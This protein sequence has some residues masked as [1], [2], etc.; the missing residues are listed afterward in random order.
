MECAPTPTDITTKIAMMLA[1]NGDM[2]P[3]LDAAAGMSG[4]FVRDRLPWL[5]R[6]ITPG[7][8]SD[9]IVCAF[10]EAYAEQ[11][12]DAAAKSF[13][14]LEDSVKLELQRELYCAAIKAMVDPLEAD[15]IREVGDA[16]ADNT[17]KGGHV[18]LKHLDADL[19]AA[20]EALD[21]V[22]R[23]VL[24]KDVEEIVAAMI[25]NMPIVAPAP[26]RK[27]Q[28]ADHASTQDPKKRK[29]EN[30]EQTECARGVRIKADVTAMLDKTCKSKSNTVGK[31][32]LLAVCNPERCGNRAYWSGRHTK[33]WIRQK[34]IDKL[35]EA[36]LAAEDPSSVCDEWKARIMRLEAFEQL[37]SQIVKAIC[38]AYGVIEETRRF[39]NPDFP[40]HLSRMVGLLERNAVAPVGAAQV[41]DMRAKAAEALWPYQVPN[42]IADAIH[43]IA[44]NISPAGSKPGEGVDLA[45][46]DELER[47]VDAH[48][49]NARAACNTKQPSTT[50]QRMHAIA[51][52]FR[53]PKNTFKLD[54]IYRMLW[55]VEDF[56]RLNN[57][58]RN[59][60][61]KRALDEFEK[62]PKAKCLASG[63]VTS[64]NSGSEGRLCDIEAEIGAAVELSLELVD[65]KP[66]W[67]ARLSKPMPGVVL[68]EPLPVETV[69]K[70]T[71]IGTVSESEPS[72]GDEYEVV[73]LP[74]LLHGDDGTVQ[75]M[76]I[77]EVIKRDLSEQ[78]AAWNEAT[79]LWIEVEPED[80]ACA[81]LGSPD[82]CCSRKGACLR[83]CSG[84]NRYVCQMTSQHRLSYSGGL[85]QTDGDDSAA[86]LCWV[87]PVCTGKRKFVATYLKWVRAIDPETK[88][89]VTWT[90]VGSPGVVDYTYNVD[91]GRTELISNTIQRSLVYQVA[92]RRFEDMAVEFRRFA[93]TVRGAMEDFFGPKRCILLDIKVQNGLIDKE[94]GKIQLCDTGC[95]LKVGGGTSFLLGPTHLPPATLECLHGFFLE[96]GL[97][98]TAVCTDGMISVIFEGRI[99]DGSS[100][101]CDDPEEEDDGCQEKTMDDIIFTVMQRIQNVLM[102]AGFIGSIGP[103]LA[104]RVY[105]T[106]ASWM[107]D[108]CKK[109]LNP[110]EQLTNDKC[111]WFNSTTAASMTLLEALVDDLTAQTCVTARSILG[112]LYG[113]IALLVDAMCLTKVSEKIRLRLT[114]VKHTA[115]KHMTAM[116]FS[117][118]SLSERAGCPL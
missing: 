64:N 34:L 10:L 29:N 27:A 114:A 95:V 103:L 55:L 98:A 47:L 11:G 102:Y 85:D 112:Q 33:K 59:K 13:E 36:C 83:L 18:L 61:F 110:L 3:F 26:K 17:W 116:N 88:K 39:V 15:Q 78:K 43:L 107:P 79:Q 7:H 90:S 106:D 40:T 22:T 21:T 25:D 115:T 24:H 82:C 72:W 20:I 30:P 118:D 96:A 76:C 74:V 23:A 1:T 97:R 51:R 52:V 69:S 53:C 84:C 66:V 77:V 81:A 31:A 42:T 56:T 12:P 6:G 58:N 89:P 87:C 91:T 32:I 105:A 100:L 111:L 50:E 94:F 45:K 104:K 44:G 8:A 49:P 113:Y 19:T 65:G 68:G 70:P 117:F 67:R 109:H 37:G 57:D 38:P 41:D 99:D 101:P 5:L 54:A 80:D 46:L 108:N 4:A 62:N 75:K 63:T 92:D 48:D 2:G 73:G 71:P 93:D 16:F 28:F 14:A 60:D 35:T 86:V 9:A